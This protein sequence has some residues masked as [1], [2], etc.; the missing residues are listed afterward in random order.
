MNSER[1]KLIASLVNTSD[2]VLDVGC[3]HG[4]LS[5]YLKQNNLC[6]DVFA[7]DI[8]I[9][10]LSNARNNFKKNNLDIKTFVS[11]GFKDIPVY[12]NT[13][14]IA[15]MG[16]NT[17]LNIL[18]NE[19]KPNKLILGSQN[20]LKLLRTNLNKMNYKLVKEKVIYENKH[21]YVILEYVKG[22]EKLSKKKLKF[23]ISNNN[24]YYKYLISKNNEILKRVPLSKKIKLIYD[25]LMLKSLI[26]RK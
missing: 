15:G 3:D 20:E 23:G 18:N 12:F 14:V 22:K 24:D 25:N 21:Y 7:S 5:M 17:I 8:S 13:A 19:K 16:T 10:A 11:D 1:L 26:K 4:Y 2:I 6:K 9:N